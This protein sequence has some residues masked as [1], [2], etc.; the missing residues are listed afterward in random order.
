MNG[1][2]LAFAVTLV[3]DPEK[4]VRWKALNFLLMASLE[5]LRSALFHFEEHIPESPFRDE[6]RWM[7]SPSALDST[8]IADRLRESSLRHR[9]FAAV[10]AAR[11]ASVDL[12]CL[13]DAVDSDDPEVAQFARDA[14]DRTVGL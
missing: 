10:A 2:E 1:P 9:K 3:D 4:A 8:G 13:R 11:R 12:Q 6:L 7:L 14:L 5:Q